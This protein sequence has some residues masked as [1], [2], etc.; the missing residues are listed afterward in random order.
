MVNIGTSLGG[1]SGVYPAFTQNVEDTYKMQGMGQ[2]L[3]AQEVLGRSMPDIARFLQMMSVQGVPGVS[4]ITP[5]AGPPGGPPGARPGPPMPP[6][7][8]YTQGPMVNPNNPDLDP[9]NQLPPIPM[10]G[11][12]PP[13]PPVGPGAPPS[14]SPVGPPGPPA[15]PQMPPPQGGGFTGGMGGMGGT[16]PALDLQTIIQAV[17]R[18]NPGAPPGVIARA[19]NS[20]IPL[21][22]AQAQM[23]WR[24]MQA[25]LRMQQQQMQFLLGAGRLGVAERGLDIRQE[26]VETQQLKALEQANN[27]RRAYGLPEFKSVE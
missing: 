14:P 25:E 13:A 9:G 8:Q 27:M 3:Q 12:S 18:N 6:G 10:A 7:P 21:M 15:R 4:G 19:V 1:L 2:D 20:A 17:T 26:S 22:N 24:Q 11:G 16:G 5:G 23:E